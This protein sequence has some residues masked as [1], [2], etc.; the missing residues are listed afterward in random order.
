MR[1]ENE[2]KESE[3]KESENVGEVKKPE[4]K[5]EDKLSLETSKAWLLS[6]EI[7]KQIFELYSDETKRKLSYLGEPKGIAENIMEEIA[8]GSV[9]RGEPFNGGHNVMDQIMRLRSKLYA[10]CDTKVITIED[11][12]PI[13]VNLSKLARLINTK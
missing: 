12:T 3:K 5:I 10:E 4:V 7:H 1:K 2:K 13:L 11:T 6:R 8:C 9:D